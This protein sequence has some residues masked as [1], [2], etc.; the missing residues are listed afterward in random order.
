MIVMSDDVEY[1]W[2]DTIIGETYEKTIDFLLNVKSETDKILCKPMVNV[3]EDGI[4]VGVITETNQFVP[5]KP[6]PDYND[7]NY[8][9]VDKTIT[10]NNFNEIDTII[11]NDTSVDIERIEY[12]KRINLE[13]GFY[14]IFRNTIRIMLSEH[15]N[16]A[17]REEIET[18][19][20]S[21][22]QYNNKLRAI[23]KIIQTMTRNYFKFSDF[24]KEVINDISNIV[25]CYKNDE[26]LDKKYCII[27][28]STK[29]K[30]MMIPKENLINKL[31]NEKTYFGKLADE[32]L[33][34]NRIKTFIF[35][36]KTFLSLGDIGYN[37]GDDEIVLMQ[38]LLNKDYFVETDKE[39]TNEYIKTN[40]F[41][42][43]N[44]L[45]RVNYTSLFNKNEFSKSP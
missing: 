39:V 11:S 36:P 3:K 43:V 28:D 45:K 44:P 21:D 9:G 20:A 19:I 6:E 31:D 7:T 17:S 16:K 33:R 25:S 1:I 40:T 4:I 2:I 23:I 12:I 18:I 32:L 35:E 27:D 26:L 38:S 29:E 13:T 22:K 14:K 34:F 5:V 15:N 10:T 30:R 42:N 41:D 8:K 24:S 37:L